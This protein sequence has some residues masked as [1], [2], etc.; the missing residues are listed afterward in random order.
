M[1]YLNSE[2]LRQVRFLNPNRKTLNPSRHSSAEARNKMPHE[3]PAFDPR[4]CFAGFFPSSKASGFGGRGLKVS[5]TS[6]SSERIYTGCLVPFQRALR[7]I[8]LL[9]CALFGRKARSLFG[10]RAREMR[11]C[12]C[13]WKFGFIQCETVVASVRVTWCLTVWGL[14]WFNPETQNDCALGFGFGI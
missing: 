6:T 7:I 5:G 11:S 4:P 8:V 3:P 9:A 1:P 13:F 2:E 10:F 12:R 14:P